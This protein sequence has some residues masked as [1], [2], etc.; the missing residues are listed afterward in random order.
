MD[1]AAYCGPISLKFNPE[2]VVIDL[3][4][5]WSTP[6]QDFEHYPGCA[7]PVS[8]IP[9]VST[10]S[11]RLS[12]VVELSPKYLHLDGALVEASVVR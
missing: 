3:P 7:V 5:P 9:D 8:P 12:N 4:S 10:D 1:D 11:H 6:A 2:H